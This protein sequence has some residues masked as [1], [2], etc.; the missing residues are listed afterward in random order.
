MI[1]FFFKD[2]LAA[3]FFG[4]SKEEVERLAFCSPL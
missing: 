4:D 2:N 3:F 1:I